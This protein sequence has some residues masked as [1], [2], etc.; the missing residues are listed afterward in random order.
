MVKGGIK[1][2]NGIIDDTGETVGG[3][4]VYNN[5]CFNSNGKNDIIALNV[6]D[7]ITI[8]NGTLVFNNLANSISGHRSDETIF[9]GEQINPGISDPKNYKSADLSVLLNLSTE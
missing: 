4:Y 2:K 9:L 6:Q 7:N 3:H 8:N 5:T 1:V